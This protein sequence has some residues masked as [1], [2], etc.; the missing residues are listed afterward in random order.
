MRYSTDH[1][2]QTREKIVRAA[3]RRFRSGGAKGVAIADLMRELRL[4]H[5]G[6]YKHF[7][8]KEQ[9]FAEALRKAFDDGVELLMEAVEKAPKGEELKA[10]IE[11]YLSDYHCDHPSEGCPV[12]S[13]AGEL[14]YHPK[15]IRMVFDRVLS[16]YASHFASKYM[17][18]KTAKERFSKALALFS[19][20]AGAIIIARA[21]KD[22]NL[23]D[24]ILQSAR[25]TYIQAFCS[26]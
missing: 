17:M 6:F 10:L 16:E 8:S 1:K 22:N 7:N 20:M 14:G 9:L 19:G 2:K 12:A 23:R 18:G 11:A 3:S 4:T 25:D 26:A 15:A 5:G 24:T 21:V 13:L